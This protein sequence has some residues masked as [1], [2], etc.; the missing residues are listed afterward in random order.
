LPA[1]AEGYQR[2][3]EKLRGNRSPWPGRENDGSGRKGSECGF[4][5]PCRGGV[6]RR[7]Q[8]KGLKSPSE[9]LGTNP[10]SGKNS[11]GESEVRKKLEGIPFILED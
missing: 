7:L 10:R 4:P 6:L 2:R 8:F 1:G 5:K 11:K 9:G 3:E